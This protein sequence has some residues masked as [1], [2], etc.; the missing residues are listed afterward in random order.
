MS[1]APPNKRRKVVKPKQ[2]ESPSLN[3]E[4]IQAMVT[5]IIPA[6]TKGVVTSLHE[7][8]LIGSATHDKQ[9][10]TD[11]TLTEAEVQTSDS[12]R[13]E[14]DVQIQDT[15]SS[16]SDDRCQATEH[17]VVPSTS[18]SQPTLTGSDNP[19]ISKYVTQ[20]K[21]VSIARP[22]AL[23]V[24]EKTKGKIWANQFVEFHSLFQNN[25]TD[26]LEL[27]DNGSG[28]LTCKRSK[29]G[30]IKTVD[31]WFEAFHVFVAIYT[32]RLP[33]EAPLLMK[34]A[35][36]IQRLGKQ[37]GDAAALFYDKQFRLWREDQPELLPWDQVNNELFNQALAMGLYKSKPKPNNAFQSKTKG[38]NKRHCFRFNN[39]N[40]QCGRPNCPFP[41]T[42][43]KCNGPHSKKQCTNTG[44]N[45]STAATVNSNDKRTLS[46]NSK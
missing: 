4:Q 35:D 7:M 31:K 13:Q 25:E 10:T 18:G 23:G 20:G 40:G 41:H 38:S 34:Y 2:P 5:A 36:T 14:H 43:Q 15:S 44:S 12:S 21:T 29:S 17:T 24:E 46:S 42:C 26:K 28:V 16:V 8:G 32:A 30:S 27:V 37:A 11:N 33:A 3:A 39:Y 45:N 9:P 19:V 1:K 6:V 22:L